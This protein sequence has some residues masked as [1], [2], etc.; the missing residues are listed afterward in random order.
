MVISTGFAIRVDFDISKEQSDSWRAKAMRRVLTVFV[1]LTLST[2][3]AL[4]ILIV[5]RA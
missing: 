4:V 5:S 2:G 1:V 3:R